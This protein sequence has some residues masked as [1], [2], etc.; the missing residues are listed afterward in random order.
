MFLSLLI[1]QAASVAHAT[2]FS[3][4]SIFVCDPMP[5]D[6]PHQCEPTGVGN[7]AWHTALDDVAAPIALLPWMP[8]RSYTRPLL[9][10]TGLLWAPLSSD[11]A[12]SP[13]SPAKYV[14]TALWESLGSPF[15]GWLGF[16]FFFNGDTMVPGITAIV[17]VWVRFSYLTYFRRNDAATTLSMNMSDVDNPAT[18]QYS[19]GEN[20]VTLTALMATHSS[21]FAP[22]DRVGLTGF[23]RDGHLDAIAV[24]ELTVEPLPPTQGAAPR[25]LQ[26]A[27]PRV[28]G[29]PSA[30]LGPDESLSDTP[31][32]TGRSLPT[33]N[34]PASGTEVSEP[35]PSTPPT[36]PPDTATPGVAGT[37]DP[38]G[39]TPAVT[40]TPTQVAR[41]TPKSSTTPAAPTGSPAHGTQTPGT[42]TPPS[43]E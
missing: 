13:L 39:R 29:P 26:P 32:G 43:L 15:P 36:S 28:V 9:N 19:D 12:S 27:S 2:N 10:P 11:R 20:R 7:V 31:G 16:N 42:P 41:K 3:G 18:L 30:I 33:P 38:N 21:V 4:M 34:Q 23:G 14:F 40:R 6:D 25:P 35:W 24:I 1:A 22:V 8:P 5:P 37:P 17:P